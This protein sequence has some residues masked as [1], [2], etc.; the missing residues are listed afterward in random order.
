MSA[1]LK[2]AYGHLCELWWHLTNIHLTRPVTSSWG[3]VWLHV[4]LAELTVSFHCFVFVTS[5][6]VIGLR[7]VCR[8]SVWMMNCV[9]SSTTRIWL[10][11]EWGREC[12]DSAITIYLQIGTLWDMPSILMRWEV[13]LNDLNSYGHIASRQ[14]AEWTGKTAKQETPYTLW[15]TQRESYR[16]S[17]M[18]AALQLADG[19]RLRQTDQG[20]WQYEWT[21]VGPNLIYGHCHHWRSRV[22]LL[23][24]TQ[25]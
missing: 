11:V 23:A 4:P 17:H 7:V 25:L 13:H 19:D 22:L 16:H 8:K 21:L 20:F 12:W 9:L 2:A 15:P 3:P 24:R 18:Q 1:V 14:V 5:R 6:L 10:W